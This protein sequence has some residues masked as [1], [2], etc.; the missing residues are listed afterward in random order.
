M[1]AIPEPRWRM[2][3]VGLG[4]LVPVLAGCGQLETPIPEPEAR[5]ESEPDSLSDP[6][7]DPGLPSDSESESEPDTPSDSEPGSG[8]GAPS[9]PASEPDPSLD[10]ESEP[11]PPFHQESVAGLQALD[12]L[13]QASAQ[14]PRLRVAG[15]VPVFVTAEV[16]VSPQLADH[17][18]G[19]A[20]QYLQDY[21][22]LY[23]MDDPDQQLFLNRVRSNVGEAHVFFYQK[24]DEV[25][26]YAAELAVHI[27]NGNVVITNGHYLPV[28]QVSS[29]PTLSA[30]D[31]EAVALAGAP[32]TQTALMGVPKLMYFDESLLTGGRWDTHLAWRIGV[33]GDR[34]SDGVATSW[35]VFVDAHDGS[36]L[37]HYDELVTNV[38]DKSFHIHSANNT[39]ADGNCN[40]QSSD[41]WFDEDGDI[42][43][44]GAAQDPFLDGLKAANASHQVYDFFHDNFDRHSWDDGFFSEHHVEIVV[45]V[46]ADWENAS[47]SSA[48][49]ELRFGDGF[50]T[51]DI[52]AH[53][54][55]HAID[56]HEGE[57]I[58][59]LYSGALDESFADVFACFVDSADWLLGEDRPAG[60]ARSLADPPLY[61]QPDHM[62]DFLVTTDDH[63]G[64]HTNSGIPNKAA[65]LIIEGGQHNGY[66]IQG[67]GRD[68]AMQLY[69]K[70][71]T[72]GVTSNTDFD[73]MRDL[74]VQFAFQYG[75]QWGFT[76][77]DICDVRNAYASVGIN[78]L[79]ADSDCDMI[80]DSSESDDDGDG[81]WDAQD[82]CPHIPN[83]FQEDMDGDGLGNF[84]DPDIDGD[85]V[86]NEDDNCPHHPNPDQADPDGDG[87]GTVCD[88]CPDVPNADQADCDQNGIGRACDSGKEF[89]YG[90]DCRI[91][92]TYHP[93]V[94]PMDLVTLPGCDDCPLTEL[95]ESLVRINVLLPYSAPVKVVDELGHVVATGTASRE[96]TLEFTPEAGFFND[97]FQGMQFFLEMPPAS[98][99]YGADTPLEIDIQVEFE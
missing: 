39:T 85:G 64:V 60:A 30:A 9:D 29:D 1:N 70:V 24:H 89:L 95:Q 54:W 61:S 2:L 73:D 22:E 66:I 12:R 3:C 7:S 21:K 81:I 78:V 10:D 18:T 13:R 98:P 23:R 75:G 74:M 8:P 53:E 6:E 67:I 59:S 56:D 45:H 31:A 49:S 65:Y 28:I 34:A 68:K 99:D 37:A 77:D 51:S 69:Y 4:V 83:M 71:L 80:P 14:W 86:P 27:V 58:Y 40:W 11:D 57:L 76:S 91:P 94:H 5:S 84:C 79:G 25:P 48:C 52:L 19:G 26:V 36:L 87:I 32:G 47:Y 41:W 43:Y 93:W 63:G 62:D 50:V 92:R 88:N 44:P 97:A 16:P 82:N 20:L 17:P 42:G 96:Q 15:G 90:D 46:G 55:T 72:N 35:M 38:P 33:R